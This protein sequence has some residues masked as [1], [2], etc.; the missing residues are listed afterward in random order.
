MVMSKRVKKPVTKKKADDF[1]V[2]YATGKRTLSGAEA[3]RRASNDNKAIG[4]ITQRKKTLSKAD[5]IAE[6]SKSSPSKENGSYSISRI[7]GSRLS[8]SSGGQ[9]VG[10]SFLNKAVYSPAGTRTKRGGR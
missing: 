3:Y 2:S 6:W 7:P 4:A 9:R 10:S 5:V 8:V 1:T